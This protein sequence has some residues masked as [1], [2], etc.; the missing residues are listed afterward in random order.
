MHAQLS[1]AADWLSLCLST[2]ATEVNYDVWWFIEK[3][4]P[5]WIAFTEKIS[6]TNFT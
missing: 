1:D 5:P 6:D 3:K 2:V 4:V